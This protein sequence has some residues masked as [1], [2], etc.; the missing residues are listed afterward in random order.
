MAEG[1]R[2]YAAA[3]LLRAS[4]ALKLCDT[5]LRV[6]D[7]VELLPAFLQ[8]RDQIRVRTAVFALKLVELRNAAFQLIVFLRRE[9]QTLP[10]IPQGLH[11]VGQRENCVVDALCGAF[12]LFG[13]IGGTVGIIGGV[14]RHGDGVILAAVEKT[15][16]LIQ[17]LGQ[18]LGVS[19]QVAP[20]AEPVFLTGFQFRALQL[21]DLI[22]QAFTQ[23]LLLDLIE[24]E[25]VDLPADFL[26]L[27]V[28]FSIVLH[29]VFQSA[30][31]IQILP[32]PTLIH[33]L[34]SVVLPVNV[35]KEASE[36]TKLRRGDRRAAHAA[37]AFA[38][39]ADTALKDE[40]IVRLNLILSQPV[41]HVHTHKHRG[42]QCLLRPAAHQLPV[43][44]PAQHRADGVNDDGFAS[45][46]LTGQ[47]VESR[48]KANIRTLDHGDIFYVQLTEH[49]FHSK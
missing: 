15:D 49:D 46:G 16:R 8:I 29:R 27:P 14:L 42:H 18:L 10:E 19:E 23:P 32:V 36:L 1:G 9:I 34:A 7:R 26:V 28:F 37:A 11:R 44:A 24:R 48:V 45:A 38:V 30:E 20:C 17:R 2:R 13:E 43:H 5:L 35:H 22:L 40:L 6:L 47:N 21:L 31:A 39:G 12:Q 41:L 4:L 33:E 25:L 3:L